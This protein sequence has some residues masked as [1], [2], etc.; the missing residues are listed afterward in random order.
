M[1]GWPSWKSIWSWLQ[2]NLFTATKTALQRDD[3]TWLRTIG[4]FPFLKQHRFADDE[5]LRRLV[6]DFL[7]SKEFAGVN[8][9]TISDDIAVA[10]AAQAC[11]PLLHMADPAGRVQGDVLSWYDDFVTVVVHPSDMLA[12]RTTVDA[13]GVAH[14]YQEHLS[15]EAMEGGPVTL[16]WQNVMKA[17]EDAPKGAN[18]VIHE[19]AHKLDMRKGVASGSPAMA[20]NEQSLWMSTM[21]EAFAEFSERVIRAQRF[22]EPEP[23]L[24]CYGATSPPEFFAVCCEAYFV[25]RASF[26][27]HHPKV[28]T[29]F[30]RF[31]NAGRQILADGII[32][33]EY[34]TNNSG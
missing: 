21:T 30:D 14:F 8:G 9:M 34:P 18:L 7:R 16:S 3:P 26:T 29:L 15:G 13:A 10:I 31:F 28:S 33:P 22:G 23:W 20:A 2:G 1:R 27:T 32:E 5:R 25:N 11:L 19:F 4:Q 6:T 17:S 24:D 12:R